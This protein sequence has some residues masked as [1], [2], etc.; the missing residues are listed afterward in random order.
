MERDGPEAAEA[1]A[2]PR[3][4]TGEEG[5]GIA[6]GRAYALHPAIRYAWLAHR[7]SFWTAAGTAFGLLTLYRDGFAAS[8]LV[9]VLL[10]TPLPL[11]VIACHLLQPLLAYR[12]VSYE[13]REHDFVVRRGVLNRRT[14]A[15]PLARI[16]QVDSRSGPLGRLLGHAEIVIHT[17]GTRVARTVLDGIPVR[18]AELLRNRLSRLGNV[19]AGE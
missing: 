1:G 8:S 5:E 17:A 10:A 18:R 16:Q 2:T 13:L 6:L 12:Y 14:V 9:S 15:I 11:L 19:H 4:Q 3:E 7:V